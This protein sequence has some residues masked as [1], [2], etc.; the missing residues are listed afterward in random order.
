MTDLIGVRIAIANRGEVAVRI[1]MTCRRLG[2]QPV[3][4][5][6][7]PDLDGFAARTVG[8]VERIGEAGAELDVERVVA[9]AKRAGAAY[10]HPGY[11]FLSERAELSAA[12]AD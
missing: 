6:G 3:L 7:D 1:A 2:A 10:L 5:L 4:L 8:R 12:C 11:G 9:A